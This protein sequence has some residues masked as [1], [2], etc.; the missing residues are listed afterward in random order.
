MHAL[1]PFSLASVIVTALLATHAHAACPSPPPPVR[2]VTLARYY[3]DAA[4]SKVDPELAEQHRRETAPLTAF[5]GFV[6]KQADKAHLQRSLPTDTAACALSWINGWA[7]AGAYLGAIDGKQAEAQR[8]WDLAGIALAY[9]KLKQWATAE[10]RAGIEPWLL[11]VADSARAHFDDPGVKRNN[12]W[13]WMGLGLGAVGI[14]AESD[15]HFQMA[16]GIMQNASRDISTGGV[17]PLELARQ[18]RALHY[19]AFAAMPLVT[20]AELAASKGEDWYALGDGALH[21]FVAK[22]VAGLED[23]AVFDKLAGAAQERP[24]KSGAGWIALYRA[25]FPER[26]KHVPKQSSAHRWLGGDVGVLH[27]VLTQ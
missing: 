6:T 9:L 13:Y 3:S 16:K 27:K 11:K 2:D 17:L 8:K 19:H 15:K 5:V 18:A 20:L 12:H 4:G 24:V 10:D 1:A 26:L 23:P 7:A 21:R 14:A 25:R 22:T